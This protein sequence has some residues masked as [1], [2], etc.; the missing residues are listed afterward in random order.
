MDRG[1]PDRVLLRSPDSPPLSEVP[2]LHR[3]YEAGERS[4]RPMQTRDIIVIGASAIASARMKPTTF[5]TRQR[6]FFRT[7]T[8]AFIQV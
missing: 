1:L 2:M 8:L 4:Y 5:W 6:A 7:R 3:S